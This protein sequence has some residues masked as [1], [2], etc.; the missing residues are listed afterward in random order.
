MVGSNASEIY[1][2]L[3]LK[4]SSHLLCWGGG[5]RVGVST[6]GV[7]CSDHNCYRVTNICYCVTNMSGKWGGRGKRQSSRCPEVVRLEDSSH[8]K[9]HKTGL[10]KGEPQPVSL[11]QNRTSARAGS[12][13]HL[14]ARSACLRPV[15]TQRSVPPLN[16]TFPLV[17]VLWFPKDYFLFLFGYS[18]LL[19]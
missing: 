18:N 3:C 17:T 8:Q 10:E 7:H 4:T 13:S 12:S 11:Q 1:L 14:R 15:N 6:V 2:M 9:P 19:S 5:V 16:L